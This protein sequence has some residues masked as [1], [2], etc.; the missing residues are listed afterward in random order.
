[1]ALAASDLSTDLANPRRR[2]SIVERIADG[3]LDNPRIAALKVRRYR[4]RAYWRYS[5]ATSPPATRA[6]VSFL[7]S[8]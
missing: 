6:L 8:I 1:M 5:T 3:K 4:G 7:S 2:L